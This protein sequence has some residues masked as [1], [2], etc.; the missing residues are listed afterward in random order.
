MSDEQ[1]RL[2]P[3]DV[4][5]WEFGSALRG[6][7]RARVDEFKARVADEIEELARRINDLDTKSRGFHDQ[8]RSFRERDRAINDALVSAQQ[9]RTDIREQAEKE[10]SLVLQEARGDA[11]KMLGEAKLEA[12]RLAQQSRAEAD[13]V[14]TEARVRSEEQLTDARVRSEEQL[15]DARVRSEE[16]LTDAKYRAEEMLREARD[17]VERLLRDARLEARSLIDDSRSSA[18][19]IATD[20]DHL[21][22]THRSFLSQMKALAERHLQDV[23]ASRLAAPSLPA[24]ADMYLHE[25]DDVIDARLK[26][27]PTPLMSTIVPAK[28]TITDPD[29]VRALTDGIIPHSALPEA[30]A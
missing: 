14:L 24:A 7:D 12:D 20:L 8:I 9:L 28:E 19:R 6:Y 13:R 29:T 4:R 27:R 25:S 2:T 30:T 1:F 17:E 23:E 18:K 5:R 16:Q 11:D 10:G 15:T 22:R 3:L 21:N 26:P